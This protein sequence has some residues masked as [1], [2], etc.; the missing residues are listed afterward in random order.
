MN[1]LLEGQAKWFKGV[2]LQDSMG[3]L[4]PGCFLHAK[5]RPNGVPCRSYYRSPDKE[6]NSNAY[7]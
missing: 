7:V 3:Q 4:L 5:L 6:Q 1:V 2:P